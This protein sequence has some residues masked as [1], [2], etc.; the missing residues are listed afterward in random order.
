MNIPVWYLGNNIVS[1]S[2]NLDI[3]DD[4][5]YI[6]KPNPVRDWFRPL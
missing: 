5:D 2:E 1:S 3:S 4:V 6:I